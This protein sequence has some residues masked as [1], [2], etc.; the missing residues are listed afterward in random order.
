MITATAALAG[1]NITRIRRNSG[2]MISATVIP[3]IFLVALYAV[4]S[5][6]M[7]ANGIDYAQ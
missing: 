7:E 5:T 4:F 3:G 1:R 2:S 6:A